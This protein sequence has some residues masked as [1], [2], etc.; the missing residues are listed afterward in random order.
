MVS[1]PYKTIGLETVIDYTTNGEK[2]IEK[3]YVTYLNCLFD[4]P[5]L[6]MVNTKR[7]F[8]DE[9]EILAF[10]GYQSFEEDE[11]NA[12]LHIKLCVEFAKKMWGDSL[13]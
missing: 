8:H 7:H 2:T 10:H 5:K 6:S 11:V 1:N 12:D 13:M 9:S 3:R 4:N